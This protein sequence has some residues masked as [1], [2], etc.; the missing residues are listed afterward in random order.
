MDNKY[1]IYLDN[2][3]FNRP[4]DEQ[5]VLKNYLEAEAK[6]YIQNEI[7]NN[8][9]ELVWSYMMDYEIS[10]NPFNDR[11]IQILKWKNIAV[12]DIDYSENNVKIAN[13][14]RRKNI[15]IRVKDSIH[16]ACS[17]EAKCDYFITTDEKLLK[18]FVDNI[19]IINPLN[20]IQQLEV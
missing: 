10:F 1:R 19:I 4:Y 11:K 18:K 12:V 15:N 9:F 14:I 5:S 7:R 2:C 17:I 3:S 13:D 8:T 20:F 6:L 16:L